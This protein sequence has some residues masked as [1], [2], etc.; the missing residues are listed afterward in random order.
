LSP[1]TQQVRIAITRTGSQIKAI[2]HE[3]LKPKLAS[4]LGR[5]EKDT[6]NGK[7]GMID[8]QNFCHPDSDR[9]VTY[10]FILDNDHGC[11]LTLCSVGRVPTWLRNESGG[12]NSSPEDTPARGKKGLL[13][14]AVAMM[15][16]GRK[17]LS[18]FTAKLGTV[19]ETMNNSSLSSSEQRSLNVSFDI[20][21][22]RLKSV[23]L[24]PS[25]NSRHGFRV[26]T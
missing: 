13:D 8:F 20:R 26:R 25:A 21:K 10:V 12:G 11:P 6:G 16:E 23:S 18:D 3:Y 2:F 17:E 9:W 24:I 22:V 14:A 5:Y 1:I 19:F 15:S 4:A 7:G